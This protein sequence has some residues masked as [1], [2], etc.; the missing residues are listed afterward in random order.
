MKRLSRGNV[1]SSSAVELV[2]RGRGGPS[3]SSWE[4][5]SECGSGVVWDVLGLAGV[6]VSALS[7]VIVVCEDVPSDSECDFVN[8]SPFLSRSSVISLVWKA[9]KT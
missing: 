4:F 3:V 5:V 9:R 8:R 2:G 6:G 1:S 7:V